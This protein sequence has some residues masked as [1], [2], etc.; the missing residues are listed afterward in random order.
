V[1]V[2]DLQEMQN[3]MR[4]TIDQGLQQLQSK[5]G[6]GGIPAL[7]PSAKGQP[8]EAQYAAIAPPP[9]PNAGAEIQQQ[10]Q[11]ADQTENAVSQTVG[12]PAGPFPEA[13]PAAPA[14]LATVGLG[15]TPGQVG[16]A[17]GAPTKVAN[18][19]TT[20]VYYYNGKKVTFS[21]GKVSD[22]Q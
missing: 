1:A 5:Q 16:A 10:V 19:E 6:T 2:G 8:A 20:A 15:Q 13:A 9:D 12:L 4:E 21:N 14:A 3:H 17:V 18:L 11:Q 7:P 22:G